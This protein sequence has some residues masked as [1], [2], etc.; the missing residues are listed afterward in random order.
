MRRVNTRSGAMW[1]ALIRRVAPRCN[2]PRPARSLARSLALVKGNDPQMQSGRNNK[3][4]IPSTHTHTHAANVTSQ[5]D[6]EGQ[7]GG[8]RPKLGWRS[9]SARWMWSAAFLPSQGQT[10]DGWEQLA[11]CQTAL[12]SHVRIAWHWNN[13]ICHVF[14]PWEPKK[15]L[16]GLSLIVSSL[17]VWELVRLCLDDIEHTT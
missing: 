7:D 3:E 13:S 4:A 12:G 5:K 17:A 6:S 8:R 1:I 16:T 10:E 15:N 14:F 2:Y 11:P 9:A